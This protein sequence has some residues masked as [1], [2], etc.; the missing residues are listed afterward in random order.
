MTKRTLYLQVLDDG[1]I[2]EGIK[3]SLVSII[4]PMAGKRMNISI[5]ETMDKRSR[6]QNDFYWAGIVPHVRKV[7]FE[8]GDPVSTEQCHEDLLAQFAP[9]VVRT[10]LDNSTYTRPMRSKEMSVAEFAAFITAI[11]ETMAS[12]GFPVPTI[13]Y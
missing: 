12:F 3:K 5:Q 2:P 1:Q 4:K 8:S 13:D 7:R 9:T 6:N 10:K 11:T